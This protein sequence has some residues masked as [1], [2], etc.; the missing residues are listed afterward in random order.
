MKVSFLHAL[1]ILIPAEIVLDIDAEFTPGSA[2][3]FD[4]RTG[5]AEPPSNDEAELNNED[6]IERQVRAWF[7]EQCQETLKQWH[8]FTGS[9]EFTELVKENVWQG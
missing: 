7:A 6:E 1:E 9:P 5:D 3:Y 4:Y 8:R 2:G